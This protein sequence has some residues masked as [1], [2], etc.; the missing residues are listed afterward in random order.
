MPTVVLAHKMKY[1]RLAVLG[2]ALLMSIGPAKVGCMDTD[3]GYWISDS[4]QRAVYDRLMGLMACPADADKGE[5]RQTDAVACNWFLAKALSTLYKVDDLGPATNG[6]W[7][8]ANEI[9]AWVRSHG[10]QW[11]R[12]GLA[13]DQSVLNDA[14]LG[15]ANGQPNI[16]AMQGDPHGN[17]TVVISGTPKLS[18]T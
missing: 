5:G 7:L 2:A 15:A 9:V 11:T 14:A 18:T 16:A 1:W 4:G 12:L 3:N 10:A 6:H 8:T 17:V 13:N